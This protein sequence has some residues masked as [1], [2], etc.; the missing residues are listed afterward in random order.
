MGFVLFCFLCFCFCSQL[1]P[2]P[3]ALLAV[4][5]RK[6]SSSSQSVFRVQAEYGI[7]TRLPFLL[8]GFSFFFPPPPCLAPL[9]ENSVFSPS[10][11]SRGGET[12]KRRRASCG[13]SAFVA[14]SQQKNLQAFECLE[15]P[16]SL[17][18]SF[19]MSRDKQGKKTY[20]S[21]GV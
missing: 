6:C 1:S 21:K 13:F 3:A 18:C 12:E 9:K 16:Q 4:G 19:K 10:Y 7:K 11:T 14:P 5:K 17:D 8:Q 20:V 2:C 15:K